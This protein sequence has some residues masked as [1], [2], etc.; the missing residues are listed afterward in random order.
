MLLFFNLM[1]FFLWQ[2]YAAVHTIQRWSELNWASH[3]VVLASWVFYL[4]IRWSDPMFWPDYPTLVIVVPW[5]EHRPVG[6]VENCTMWG[7]FFLFIFFGHACT[8]IIW[9][10]TYIPRVKRWVQSYCYLEWL[11]TL[12][13]TGVQRMWCS[14]VAGF[15]RVVATSFFTTGFLSHLCLWINVSLNINMVLV[16]VNDCHYRTMKQKSS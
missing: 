12:I 11:T 2:G 13:L 8:F 6:E 1:L 7:V 5:W 10:W 15:S 4:L 9:I 14:S 3:W 16:M